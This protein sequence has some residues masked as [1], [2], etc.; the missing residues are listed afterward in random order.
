MLRV[1][2]AIRASGERSVCLH[3]D[4][5]AAAV[6]ADTEGEGLTMLKTGI[7]AVALM[8]GAAANAGI[9]F[10]GAGGLI[11][12]NTGNALQSN[13]TSNTVAAITD[14][15][16]SIDVQH[17]YMGHL[18]AQVTHVASNTSAWLFYKV[19]ASGGTGNGDASDFGGTYR[20][21]GNFAGS[22]WTAAAQASSSATVAAGDYKPTTISGASVSFTPFAGLSAN[23][24]WTLQVWDNVT[25]TVGNVEGWSVEIFVIPSP[26]PVVLAGAAGLVA[27]RRRR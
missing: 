27:L 12:D 8:A 14:V 10:S 17:G 24:D 22:L 1:G 5:I 2:A 21:N 9:V 18:R 26:G 6:G 19:G 11:P 20:F 16:F 25:G 13:I 3:R 7:A 23:S 4:S 15:I